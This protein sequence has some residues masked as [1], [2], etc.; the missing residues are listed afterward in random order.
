MT[1]E[2]SLGTVTTTLPATQRATGRIA[3]RRLAGAGRRLL[4]RPSV[5]YV[6]LTPLVFSILEMLLRGQAAVQY[7]VDVFDSDLPVLA[8]LRAD[9]LRFGPS[10][11]DPHL[12]SGNAGLVQ[13]GPLESA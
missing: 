7:A 2:T 5:L 12:T 8:A 10:L 6:L 3:G 1:P 4:V 13:M 9:W 11:W